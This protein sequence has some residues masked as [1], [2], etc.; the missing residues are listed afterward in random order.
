MTQDRVS[1]E[2]KTVLITGGSTGIGRA[3]AVR[4]AQARARIL[5]FAREKGPLQDALTHLRSI[6]DDVAGFTADVAKP[7]DVTKIFREVDRRWNQLDILINNA[8]IAAGPLEKLDAASLRYAVETNLTGYLTCSHEAFQRMA[9]HRSGHIINIGSISAKNR[10]RGAEV[11]VATKA[12]IQGFS[13]ALG[14][15]GREKGIRVSLIEPGLVG[16]DLIEQ[17][18]AAQRRLQKRKE[19][20]K[21]EDI[22]ECV[23]YCL[24]Q[25]PRCTVYSIQI[26]PMME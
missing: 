4:L 17:P 3:T 1:L 22:A 9:F 15:A 12:G 8:A 13:E 18:P 14:K 16:T 19:M 26:G 10:S 6:H 25:P 21:A 7:S 24:S 11:Y 5:I 2:G 23:Y 20:L